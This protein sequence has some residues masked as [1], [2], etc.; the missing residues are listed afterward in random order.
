MKLLE[1]IDCGIYRD[2]GSLEATWKNSEGNDFT[3][4]LK[5]NHWD[6]PLEPKTYQL[7][8]CHLKSIDQH[9][10]ILK[11]STEAAH[12]SLIHI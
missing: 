5:I 4:T 7:F 8:P 11:N 6:H 12:L 10:R 2:G 1:L 9:T 3:I